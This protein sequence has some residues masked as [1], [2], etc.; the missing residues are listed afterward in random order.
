MTEGKHASPP[1]RSRKT[2]SIESL[3]DLELRIK[4]KIIKLL[5][6]AAKYEWAHCCHLVTV[7]RPRQITAAHNQTQNQLASI[8][9]GLLPPKV[10]DGLC[11]I[12]R[13]GD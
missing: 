7:G 4:T 2:P 13:T 10:T 9:H 3:Q 11:V 1:A 12:R 5:L 6:L 8:M